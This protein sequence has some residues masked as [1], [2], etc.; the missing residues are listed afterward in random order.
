MANLHPTTDTDFQTRQYGRQFPEPHDSTQPNRHGIQNA[1]VHTKESSPPERRNVNRPIALQPG[2]TQTTP[3]PRTKRARNPRTEASPSLNNQS[4]QSQRQSK[5][6][7]PALKAAAYARAGAISIIIFSW[8]GTLWL[9]I[10]LPFAVFSIIMLGA[11]VWLADNYVYD[12][13]ISVWNY[14]GGLFGLP[15]VDVASLFFISLIITV[16]T[17]LIALIGA[18]AHYKAGFLHPLGGGGAGMKQATF[19]LAF[20]LYWVPGANLLPWVWLWMLLVL[21]YPK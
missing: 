21:R 10:Q 14:V 3:E 2:I 18:A 6:S 19:L 9:F 12:A 1:A 11:S 4:R 7:S 16:I 15:T 5:L 13:A 8:T 17:G 20:V